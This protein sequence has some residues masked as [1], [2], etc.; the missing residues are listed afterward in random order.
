[1]SWL[2]TLGLITHGS[3]ATGVCGSFHLS[4]TVRRFFAKLFWVHVV[5]ADSRVQCSTSTGPYASCHLG[6]LERMATGH[7]KEEL[8]LVTRQMR[9]WFV[10]IVTA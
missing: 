9:G 7:G 3:R 2:Y 8:D 5:H 1:M 10:A 6:V 4:Q